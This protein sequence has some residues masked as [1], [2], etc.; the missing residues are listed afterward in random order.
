VGGSSFSNDSASGNGGDI[1]VGGALS[2]Q[3]ST[4]TSGSAT[5]GGSIFSIGTIAVTGCGFTGASS[6]GGDG[7]AIDC[8][9]DVSIEGGMF[10]KNVASGN[11]GDINVG[12]A[13]SIQNS[14]FTSGSATAG[15]SIFSAGTLTVSG[16]TF[17]GV[18]AT[19]GDGGAINYSATAT[20][21]ITNSTF[22]GDRASGNGGDVLNGGTLTVQNST[23][24][25]GSA[26]AGGS[27]FSGGTLTVSGSTFNGAAATGG[28]GGA[29]NCSASLT[30]TAT[31]F[32]NN[33]ASGN[34]GGFV[35]SGTAD[36]QNCA[37]GGNSGTNGGGIENDGTL[38]LV[39]CALGGNSATDGGAINNTGTLTVL[40][41]TISGN[42]ASD[43]GGGIANASAASLTLQNAILSGNSAANGAPDLSGSI[44]PDAGNNLLGS[45]IYP[46]S[47]RAPT[48]DIITDTPGVAPLADYGGPLPSMPLLP[49]SKAKNTGNALAPGLPATDEDGD[50]RTVAGQLDIGAWE[51]HGNLVL[52]TSVGDGPGTAGQVNLREAI[53]VA[54]AW[55]SYG[56]SSTITFEAGLQRAT[57]TLSQGVLEI[58]GPPAKS[59]AVITIT[60][61]PQLTVSGD[62]L[63]A[64]LQIA[65]GMRAAIAGLTVT[66][67]NSSTPGG[68]IINNGTL[69][70]TSC[71]ISGNSTTGDG[72]GVDNTGTLT[73]LGSTFSNNTASGNGG[74]IA[75]S[76]TLTIQDCTLAGNA[77]TG[78][79]GVANTGTL[80]V[81]NSTVSHNSAT[82]GGGVTNQH[83]LKLQNTILS[84]NSAAT[85]PDLTGRIGTDLGNNLLGTS[86]YPVKAPAT[87]RVTDLA[88]LAPLGSYGGPT[89]TMPPL[90]GS[91]ARGNGNAA[92]V[93]ASATD[94]RG[95]AR[96]T[97]GRLDIGAVQMQAYPLV[98]TTAVDPGKLW[99]VLAL[100]EAVNLAN[101][102]AASGSTATIT[103]AP[104][105][106][107]DTIIL[108]QGVLELSGR[109]AAGIAPLA[110]D[111]GQVI[112][113]SGGNASTVLQVDA[114]V[115]T[116]LSGLALINGHSAG[117][118]GGIVNKGALTIQ[119]CT[120]SG[121]VAQQD[122][123]A[124][125]SAGVLTVQNCTLAGNSAGGNGGAIAGG[126]VT[127]LSST[128][129]ANTARQGG[130]I[131]NSSALTLHNS[132][133]AGNTAAVNADVLGAISSDAGNNLL[134]AAL[135]TAT[136]PSTDLFTDSPGLAAL[137][138]NGSFLQTMAL[139]PGSVALG[140]G[141]GQRAPATDERGVARRRGSHGQPIIDI[142]AFESTTLPTTRR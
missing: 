38:T 40:T 86:V 63:S 43:Q 84:G 3:N 72:G 141:S 82:S 142:G 123:G 13:L 51:T 11:G 107:G 116:I 45:A 20:A 108:T 112:T 104:G 71:I 129:S 97:A 100:R 35:C 73:V 111:G 122:G 6:T 28:D 89:P 88:G 85:G 57:I 7:G 136:S 120:L 99:G 117:S 124:I 133:V 78:G 50:R 95:F 53:N 90:P 25:S 31:F 62:G 77:A 113:I 66:G 68:G 21:T 128:V 15:G 48:S 109:T 69:T 102:W 94:Q 59:K 10:S 75:N 29:I 2:I 1:N 105:L 110:I 61:Q 39:N 81:L 5:A 37:F 22:S 23:F 17:T 70:L 103:F 54:N 76:G 60:G 47:H 96:T 132:I 93:G 49:N 140:A 91:K 101:A 41:S 55:A 114:G 42:T 130:G 58:S 126:L 138:N 9:G 4:F 139:L 115:N 137:A 12:G 52:V 125:A 135:R 26:T 106:R 79:G 87:D 80:T 18:T 64:V 127:I 131:A 44:A 14:T 74:G 16:G 92:A 8:S 24:T 134:G 98:V 46:R 36:V 67:G 118:G 33:T 32:R 19:G 119:N 30:V 56:F 65:S 83:T 34:G 121:N 27:I